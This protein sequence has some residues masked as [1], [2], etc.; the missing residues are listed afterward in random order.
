MCYV[1]TGY[2]VA[3]DPEWADRVRAH[4]QRRPAT[5]SSVESLDLAVLLGQPAPLLIDCIGLWLTRTIDA[6][7]GWDAPSLPAQ[8]RTSMDA[9]VEA[10]RRP[11][12]VAVAVTNEVGLGLVPATAAGRR[13]GDE[14]GGLNQRLAEASDAVWLLVAGIPMR[15]R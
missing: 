2:P 15:L 7:H 9:L 3:D 12:A 6:C 1:A 13:F 4:Q 11:G 5:W 14:L 10:W 8:V